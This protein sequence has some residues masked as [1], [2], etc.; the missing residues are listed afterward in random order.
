M[1][2]CVHV[3]QLPEKF[4]AILASFDANQNHVVISYDDLLYLQLHDRMR[5]FS[6]ALGAKVRRC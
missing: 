2:R 3:G 5:N 4:V 1:G 6:E